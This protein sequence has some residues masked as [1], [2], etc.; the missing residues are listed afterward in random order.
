[1][2]TDVLKYELYV[3]QCF[4]FMKSN[5][6]LLKLNSCGGMSTKTGGLV[7]LDF[8]LLLT[9]SVLF[10]LKIRFVS[11]LYPVYIAVFTGL[12]LYL[13]F[14]DGTQNPYVYSRVILLSAYCYT[15]FFLMCIHLISG[16]KSPIDC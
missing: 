8:I 12:Y 4:L 5:E 15:G 9:L 16:N 2:L 14:G 13:S 11:F 6:V 1:M 10:F 3:P 7:L